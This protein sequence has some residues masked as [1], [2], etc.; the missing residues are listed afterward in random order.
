M[1]TQYD[2]QYFSG[3]SKTSGSKR[4]AAPKFPGE[5]KNSTVQ[6]ARN[7]FAIIRCHIQKIR[8]YSAIAMALLLHVDLTMYDILAP[9][10]RE[11]ETTAYPQCDR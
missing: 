8:M 4:H 3:S 6:W 7:K 11:H 10:Q 2:S 9:I 1:S 5:K